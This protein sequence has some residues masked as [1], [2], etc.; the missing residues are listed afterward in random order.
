MEQERK[1]MNL[2]L[3]WNKCAFT[4]HHEGTRN[5]DKKAE[6]PGVILRKMV[7]PSEIFDVLNQRRDRLVEALKRRGTVLLDKTLRLS[8]RLLVGSGEPSILEVG[9][10]LSRNYGVP[11]I[12]STALKGAFRSYCE[13]AEEIPTAK[14]EELFGTTTEAG[15]LLFLDAYP[16]CEVEFGLDVI[17]NHFQPYYMKGEVPNDW[18]DPVP[19]KFI[20]VSSGTF[21]FTVL[22][23]PDSRED[24]SEELR[25]KLKEEFLKMLKIHGIGAKTNYGYGRFSS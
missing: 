24:I 22:I 2:S 12:P 9:L 16:V 20:T 17:A 7:L 3:F 5:K 15:A 18:Y 14:I 13:E 8:S 1:S 25:E 19:V 4:E 10:T 6:L 11:I 21:R 23:E